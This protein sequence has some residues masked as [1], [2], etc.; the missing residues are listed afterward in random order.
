MEKDR[1]KAGVHMPRKSRE[2][3]QSY[4]DHVPLSLFPFLEEREREGEGLGGS[5][6]EEERGGIQRWVDLAAFS[7]NFLRKCKLFYRPCA[8]HDY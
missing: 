4:C 2:E 7:A 8:Q 5:E 6:R 1:A 3:Y